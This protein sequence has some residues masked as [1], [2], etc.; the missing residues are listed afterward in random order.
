M[1]TSLPKYEMHILDPNDLLE[2]T[3]F[4]PQEDGQRLRAIIFKDIDDYDGKLQWYST[5]LKLIYSNKDDVVE[6]VFTY[7][8]I[9]DHINNSEDDDII[10]WKFKSITSHEEPLPRSYTNYNGSPHNLRIELEIGDVT[11]EPLKMIAADNLVSCA[12]CAKEKK[13]Y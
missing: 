3:F 8:E 7:N 4:I 9:L 11:N 2:R 1:S 10:E 12:T 6:D 13:N 5:R